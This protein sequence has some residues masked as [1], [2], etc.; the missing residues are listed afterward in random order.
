MENDGDPVP[1]HL[2]AYERGATEVVPFLRPDVRVSV[3]T[4]RLPGAPTT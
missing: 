1:A 3:T 2:G 4:Y